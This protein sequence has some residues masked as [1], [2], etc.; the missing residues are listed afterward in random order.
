MDDVVFNDKPKGASKAAAPIVVK[1]ISSARSLSTAC[2]KSTS[3]S[4]A[5]IAS[6]SS[7]S[8]AVQFPRPVEFV[9]DRALCRKPRS[10]TQFS[11]ARC[12]FNKLPDPKP[13]AKKPAT[14]KRK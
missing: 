9:L 1:S 4:S 13:V 3:S 8:T 2:A 12:R 10:G 14:A 5:S 6:S 7:G 11:G